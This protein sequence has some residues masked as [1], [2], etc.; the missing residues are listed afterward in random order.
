MSKP[1]VAIV[2]VATGNYLTYATKMI[3]SFQKYFLPHIHKKYVVFTDKEPIPI[4]QLGVDYLHVPVNHLPWPM[5]TMLRYHYYLQAFKQFTQLQ[6]VDYVFH[7]D[8]DV[9]AVSEVTE[10]DVLGQL[11]AVRHCGFMQ[12]RGTYEENPNSACYVDPKFNPK[13]YF[14]GSFTGGTTL[15]FLTLATKITTL[16]NQD[17]KN[18]I[19]PQWHEESALNKVLIDLEPTNVLS[20]TFHYPEGN[21]FLVDQLKNLDL[22]SKPKIIV[23]EKGSPDQV[24][25]I[26]E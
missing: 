19:I 11:T 15:N 25:K 26:R 13:Y 16:L 20:P 9:L 3:E 7:T 8:A 2:V 4:Q 1:S 23:L 17:F 21:N 18:R 12:S 10:T 22:P 6:E 5:G 14:G 24:E